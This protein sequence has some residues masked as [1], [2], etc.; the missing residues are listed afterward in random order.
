M[1]NPTILEESKEEDM[2]FNRTLGGQSPIQK[3]LEG[4]GINFE[5]KSS[6]DDGTRSLL[7]QM[8]D[9]MSNDYSLPVGQSIGQI[10]NLKNM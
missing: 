7:Q 10:S 1:H 6:I 2:S 5:N 8:R 3:R 4:T 9:N